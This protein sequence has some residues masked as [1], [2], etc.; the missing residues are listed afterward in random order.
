MSDELKVKVK[1]IAGFK[2][3]EE[4]SLNSGLNVIK[5][6]NSTGKTSF[7]KALELLSIPE[8][9]LRGKA[10]Y[11]NLMA[12]PNREKATIEI[13]NSH[14]GKRSFRRSGDN[15]T[16]VD[17]G[18][19]FADGEKV[20]EV[21]FATPENELI[22]KMLSGESIQDYIERF[23]DSEHYE[24]AISILEDIRSDLD[25]QHRMYREDLIRLEEQEEELKKEKKTLDEKSDALE[26]LPD[27]DISK[28]AEDEKLQERI[29]EKE[30]EKRNL[31][32]KIHKK[33]TEKNTLETKLGN[34]E[35]EI[36][37]R[38]EQLDDI[39]KDRKRIN[40]QLEDIDGELR[41]VKE[42]ISNYRT[43]LSKIDDELKL[44]NE[45]FQKRQKYGE[46]QRCE[47]CGQP[48]TLKQLQQWED[49]LKDA[50]KDYQSNLKKAKR[51]KEDLL[52]KQSDL[53]R[54]LQDLQ[55]LQDELNSKQ[56]TKA[57]VERKKNNIESELEDLTEKRDSIEEE[58]EDL[59]SDV[60]E[61]LVE[62]LHER[63]KLLDQIDDIE[64][65][66]ESRQER[67]DNLK[68]KTKEA[69]EIVDKMD[70][71]ED[72][73]KHMKRRK[74]E[75]VDAVREAF[76]DKIMEIYDELGFENFEEIEISRDYRVYIRRPDYNERWPMEALSTSEQIT[77]AVVL[78]IAGKE[79]YMPDYP[80]FV[81]DELVTSYDP[82]RFEKIKEY[83]A[84]VTEYTVIT[85]L[86]EEEEVGDK[87]KVEHEAVG[88]T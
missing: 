10:H 72:T 24:A 31:N 71:T 68:G 15:L 58:I 64:A 63:N 86:V 17:G 82:G 8:K 28:A 22:K 66:I 6:P 46:E 45:N 38:Q 80:F 3:S 56:K 11:M 76:N 78:L 41:V 43:Q 47:A 25:R 85:Q 2:G 55:R 49:E 84:D 87:V 40:D 53:E 77:L 37:I 20:A 65:R 79:E 14:Q 88:A 34:L 73:I 23:S 61:D 30:R 67:I 62:I 51:E 50:K 57:N 69:D 7:V 4:F 54:E 21:C 19:I 70:F 39:G 13:D 33:R 52:E 81:L 12:D 75:I 32:D 42:D 29:D 44:V 35:S 48:L 1:N 18:P 5:A 74:E 26:S 83:I 9:E 36:E 60:N 59:I 16:Q 27:I